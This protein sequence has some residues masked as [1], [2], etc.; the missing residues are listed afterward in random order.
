MTDQAFLDH[1]A[2]R[3]AALPG[4]R[5]V[6]LGGSRAQGTHAHGSDW[7]FA[8]DGPRGPRSPR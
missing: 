4:V 7:D 2:D 3:L 1:V 8:P 6:T 5:A